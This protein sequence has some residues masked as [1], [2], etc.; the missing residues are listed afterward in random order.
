[1]AIPAIRFNNPANVGLPIYGW[2]GPRRRE[3][4]SEI[5]TTLLDQSMLIWMRAKPQ[6][7]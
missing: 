2:G 4:C 3:D 1:M 7:A 6:A 5:E